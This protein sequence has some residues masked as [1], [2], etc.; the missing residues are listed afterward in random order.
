MKSIVPYVFS[1]VIWIISKCN[2]STLNEGV[3]KSYIYG[4]EGLSFPLPVVCLF[5][6]YDHGRG[7]RILFVPVKICPGER[8][9]NCQK[10]LFSLR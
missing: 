3:Q 6:S 4:T 7:Q 9:D 8:S 10:E 2:K 1:N 5:Q